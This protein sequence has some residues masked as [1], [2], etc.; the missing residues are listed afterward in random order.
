MALDIFSHVLMMIL[1]LACAFVL[2]LTRFPWGQKILI[3]ALVFFGVMGGV[4]WWILRK[5]KSGLLFQ[6]LAGAIMSF[7]PLKQ[8]WMEKASELDD[9]IQSFFKRGKKPFAQ[10]NVFHFLGKLIG[11]LEVWVIFIYLDAP[12]GW[13]DS[14]LIYAFL[15]LITILFFFIPSQIGVA[16]GGTYHLFAWVGLPPEIGVAMTIIRRIR[17]LA[18]VFLGYAL[19]AF[20]FPKN[21]ATSD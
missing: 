1:L 5:K 21:C 13:F 4:F 15:Q 2:S 17:T 14:F 19:V 8:A 7:T 9:I 16:E 18:W 3:A 12:I 20:G 6:T 10:L 11:F